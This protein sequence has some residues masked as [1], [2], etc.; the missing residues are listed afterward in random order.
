MNES[1]ASKTITINDELEDIAVRSQV[2]EF[3]DARRLNCFRFVIRDS[4]KVMKRARSN[5]H[6]NL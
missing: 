6:V 2:A 4:A 5:S 1:P 3:G